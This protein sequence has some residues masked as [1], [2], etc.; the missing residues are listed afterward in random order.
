MGAGKPISWS[1]ILPVPFPVA[2][3]GGTRSFTDHRLKAIEIGDHLKSS[4]TLT[5]GDFMKHSKFP[6]YLKSQVGIQQMRKYSINNSQFFKTTGPT[7]QH[8]FIFW[9]QTKRALLYCLG[10]EN[11]FKE[12]I[13]FLI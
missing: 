3:E 11:I 5:F 6:Y 1:S 13:H 4:P 8:S 2:A 9:N 7:R 12:N 10:F